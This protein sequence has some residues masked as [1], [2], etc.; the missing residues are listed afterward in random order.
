MIT[1]F[2]DAL[3]LAARGFNVLDIMTRAHVSLD[4]AKRAIRAAC[5][6]GVR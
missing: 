2:E 6:L 1:P 5:R 4:L 3:D